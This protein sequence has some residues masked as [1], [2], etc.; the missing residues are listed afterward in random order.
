MSNVWKQTA[1]S[2]VVISPQNYFL[3]NP[4]RQTI[5]QAEID[6]DLETVIGVEKFGSEASVCTYDMVC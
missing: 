5:Q 6:Y 1:Q 3:Q 4:I 2:T